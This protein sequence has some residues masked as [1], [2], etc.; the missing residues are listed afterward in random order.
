[1]PTKLTDPI[2]QSITHVTLDGWELVVHRNADL[3]VN[4]NQSYLIADV[5]FRDA[6]GKVIRRQQKLAQ[7]FAPTEVGDGG[8]GSGPIGV[9]V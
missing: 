8:S 4:V 6:D 5:G 1:M 3:T 2:T 7:H 9:S